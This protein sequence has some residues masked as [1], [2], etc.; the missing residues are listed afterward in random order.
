MGWAL[1][2]VGPGWPWGLGSEVG[3]GLA[4]GSVGLGPG[5]VLALGVLGSGCAMG[6]SWALGSAGVGLGPGVWARG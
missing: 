3:Y 2:S 1:G 6:S 5:C 4:L